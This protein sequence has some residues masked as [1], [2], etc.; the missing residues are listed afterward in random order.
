M[1]FRPFKG[2]ILEGQISQSTS[3]GMRGKPIGTDGK[4]DGD[5]GLMLKGM[6]SYARLLRQHFHSR[7]G[8]FVRGYGIVSLFGGG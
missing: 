2:E 4:V 3:E 6:S 8:E 5:E 7:P 1:V